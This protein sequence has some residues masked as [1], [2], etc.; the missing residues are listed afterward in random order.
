[1]VHHLFKVMHI[2]RQ[3]LCHLHN[4]YNHHQNLEEDY[5]QE[6]SRHPH[7]HR[8][9]WKWHDRWLLRC[10]CLCHILR[11]KSALIFVV[12]KF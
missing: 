7:Q 11:N 6:F 5:H 2:H 4:H 12:S 10:W 8:F 9:Q 1:M 3:A